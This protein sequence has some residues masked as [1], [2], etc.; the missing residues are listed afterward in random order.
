MTKGS[1][2]DSK[3]YTLA[4]TQDYVN[5]KLKNSRMTYLLPVDENPFDENLF[6]ENSFD[7]NPINEN[8]DE[9]QLKTQ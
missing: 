3:D 9:N 4:K 6:D 1:T 2:I 7:E 5:S 8:V